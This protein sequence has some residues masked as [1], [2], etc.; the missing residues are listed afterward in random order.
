[1]CRMMASIRTR[2]CGAMGRLS[3]NLST[4]RSAARRKCQ[5]AWPTQMSASLDWHAARSLANP[6]PTRTTSRATHPMPIAHTN[7]TITIRCVS[8]RMI[9]PHRSQH[10]ER[11]ANAAHVSARYH[12][13]RAGACVARG[14]HAR[15]GVAY[16]TRFIGSQRSVMCIR[17]FVRPHGSR[18]MNAMRSALTRRD[19]NGCWTSAWARG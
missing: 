5:C 12:G 1:M 2:S 3:R 14:Q 17:D 11:V 9:T 16:S 7:R 6:R 4:S 8:M 10:I 13:P 15:R 18:A 19:V